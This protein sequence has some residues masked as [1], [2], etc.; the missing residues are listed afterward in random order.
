VSAEKLAVCHIASGDL[1]A[2]AESQIAALLRNLAARKDL[3]LSAILLNP[4]RL[5][6][7]IQSLGIEVRVIPEN[8]TGFFGIYSQAARF[9]D[10]R[11]VRILHSHRYKENVLAALLARRCRIPFVVRTQ[12]GLP[13]PV[14]GF[15]HWKQRCLRSLDRFVAR[16]ATDRVICVSSDMGRHLARQFGSRKIIVIPNGVDPSVVQPRLN[17]EEAK[18]R[19]GIPQASFVIGFAGRLEPVKRLDIFL[20]AAKL[21]VDVKQRIS[22]VIAGAGREEAKLRTMAQSLGLSNHVFFLGHR[23]DIYDILRAFDALILCSDHEGLPMILLE[24]LCLGVVVVARDVGGLP[25]V[26]QDG[27]NGVLV[28]S[29][30]PEDMARACMRVL[31]DVPSRQRLAL[32]GARLVTENYSVES[33]GNRVAELYASLAGSR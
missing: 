7:E 4:G 25:E 29:G 18:N 26:I 11:G 17:V 15:S 13:E 32:A 27:V 23:D 1:W 2:G 22:F 24:A 31:D 9:L 30:E 8:S 28:T 19:L 33:A 5:A 16:R 21:I 10:H 12:H 20:K 6:D 14:T 3:D